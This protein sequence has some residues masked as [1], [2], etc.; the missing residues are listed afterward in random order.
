MFSLLKSKSK[1]LDQFM[2]CALILNLVWII[3]WFGGVNMS[4]AWVAY[5]G[6]SVCIVISTIL[7]ERNKECLVINSRLAGLGVFTVSYILILTLIVPVIYYG[8]Y[9][10]VNT[11]PAVFAFFIIKKHVRTVEVASM[12]VFAIILIGTCS[13][14]YAVFQSVTQSNAVLWQE[15]P[16]NYANRYGSVFVNPNHHAG[17]LNCIIPIT[18]SFLFFS[19]GRKQAKII[20][21]LAFCIM[22]LALYLTKSRGGWIAAMLVTSVLTFLCLKKSASKHS[23]LFLVIGVISF[24]AGVYYFSDGFRE[25][26]LGVFSTN[27]NQSG[28]FRAWLW[29]P[30]FEM[31]VDHPIFGVGPGQFNIR[32]PEYRTP[33]TQLNPIHVHNDFLEILVEYGI[34]GGLLVLGLIA[35]F[36]HVINPMLKREV[37]CIIKTGCV[38]TDKTFMFIGC[39]ASII[40]ILVHSFF[41]FNLRIPAILMLLSICVSLLLVLV[42]LEGV[43]RVTLKHKKLSFVYSIA[44]V[45]LVIYSAPIWFQF[46]REDRLLQSALQRFDDNPDLFSDLIEASRIMPDNPETQFWVGEEIRRSIERK[47]TRTSFSIAEALVWLNRSSSIN[48]FN[49]RTHMTIGRALLEKGDRTEAYAA[50]EKAYKMSPNDTLTI[51]PLVGVALAQGD[52]VR[53]RLL[54]DKSLSINDWDN[55]EAQNYKNILD[56]SESRR[57]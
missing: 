13:S 42:D 45:G 40:G 49:A 51:N 54:V 4:Q 18:F 28:M 56:E 22:V 21:I 16:V 5:A 50:F 53:A 37:G 24:G 17:F 14:L 19:R 43:G 20:G 1:T 47:S 35:Q 3:F 11:L 30:A 39:T 27:T 10:L 34:I 55:W 33:L 32:F 57:R 23:V 26:L 46:A 29:L 41:E 36:C 8:R 25:R 44:L 48:P 38:T 12:T 6:L 15:R 31:W 7:S 2:V 9:Q 52:S